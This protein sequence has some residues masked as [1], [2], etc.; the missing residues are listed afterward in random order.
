MEAIIMLPNFWQFFKSVKK[1]V[2]T[3]RWNGSLLSFLLLENI[4]GNAVPLEPSH[5]FI[6]P[7]PVKVRSV[8]GSQLSQN[9][10]SQHGKAKT[11]MKIHVSAQFAAG[12]DSK[13]SALLEFSIEICPL[14]R[15]NELFLISCQKS[16]VLCDGIFILFLPARASI[17]RGWFLLDK[18]DTS[19]VFEE[20]SRKK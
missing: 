8:S 16:W 4:F 10:W 5:C 17:A 18:I 11:D 2:K 14:F 1:Y 20:M 7:I 3:H 12:G 6:F 9:T 13:K 15:E 19:L